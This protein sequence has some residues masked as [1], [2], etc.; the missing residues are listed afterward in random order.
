MN[1]ESSESPVIEYSCPGNARIRP[2]ERFRSADFSEITDSIR[3][4]NTRTDE[5]SPV[6]PQL[7]SPTE[8]LEHA[9]S[10]IA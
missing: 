2:L 8:R 4:D 10:L 3:R 1:N 6:R 5:Q 7:K 9:K